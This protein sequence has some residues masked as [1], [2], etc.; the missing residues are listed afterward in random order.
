MNSQRATHR[1]RA[2][3]FTLLELMATVSILGVLLAIGV[4][5]F[6]EIIRNNRTAAQANELVTAL[7]IARSEASKRG[8]PVTVCAADAARDACAGDAVGNWANGWLIFQDANGVA[9]A[10]D[11]D[12]DDLIQRSERVADGITLVTNNRGFVRY[13]RTGSLANGATVNFDLEHEDC[14][15]TNHRSIDIDPTGRVNLRKENCS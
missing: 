3:G 5:S 11:D 7:N 2:R 9:G 14:A 6:N 10:M 8:V 1:S 4:P 15:D 12:Q 13:G